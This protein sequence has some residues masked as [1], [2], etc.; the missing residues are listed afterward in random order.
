[1]GVG[2]RGGRPIKSGILTFYLQKK[3]LQTCVATLGSNLKFNLNCKYHLASW[4]TKWHDYVPVDHH[5]DSA[6]DLT[7]YLEFRNIILLRK[8]KFV[9]C[10]RGV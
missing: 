5:I 1:M 10:V 7:G 9:G 4:A 8:V 6:T 2:L 3:T